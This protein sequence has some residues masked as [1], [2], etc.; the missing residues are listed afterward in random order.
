MMIERASSALSDRRMQIQI[1]ESMEKLSSRVSTI[2]QLR[3]RGRYDRER[4][5]SDVDPIQSDDEPPG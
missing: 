2:Q 5:F 1:F 3:I 4:V